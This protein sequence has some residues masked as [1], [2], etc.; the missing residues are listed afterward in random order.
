MQPNSKKYLTQW[1]FDVWR[2]KFLYFAILAGFMTIFPTLYIPV[3]NRDVFKHEG[4]T[5]EWG[6]VFVE[7]ILFFLGIETWKWVKRIYFRRSERA[8]LGEKDVEAPISQ[9]ATLMSNCPSFARGE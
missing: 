3:I 7:A 4:I 9:A 8:H 6:I 2:N 1:M 5:W